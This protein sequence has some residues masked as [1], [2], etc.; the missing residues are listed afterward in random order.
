MSS[1]TQAPETK[2]GALAALARACAGH[3]VRTLI[4]WVTAF[5]AVALSANLFGGAL[6]NE[7]TIPGSETQSAVDLLEEKFPE[8][9]GDAAQIVFTDDE[10]LTERRCAPGRRGR[11]AGGQRGTRRGQRR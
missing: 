10:P 5:V 2:L 3:P 6:V 11:P 4:V 1:P 8:R 7:F 9:A